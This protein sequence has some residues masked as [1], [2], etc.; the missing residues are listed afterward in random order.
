MR[1]DERLFKAAKLDYVD[2]GPDRLEGAG[3][4]GKHLGGIGD[5]FWAQTERVESHC[6]WEGYALWEPLGDRRRRLGISLHNSFT[7]SR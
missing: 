4:A 1:S 3:E 6:P 2:R 7:M 5:F